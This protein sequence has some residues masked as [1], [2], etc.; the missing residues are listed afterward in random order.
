M[1]RGVTLVSWKL[2]YG[3]EV[4]E[5]KTYLPTR[6]SRV[7]REA[8]H[9]ISPHLRRMVFQSTLAA[10]ITLHHRIHHR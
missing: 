7:A 4:N 10:A 2:I 6:E 8:L 9:E 1:I 3:D 5:L